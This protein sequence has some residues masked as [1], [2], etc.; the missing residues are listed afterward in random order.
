MM[1]L[2]EVL[3]TTRTLPPPEFDVNEIVSGAQRPASI[4]AEVGCSRGHIWKPTEKQKMAELA[5]VRNY[6][7]VNRV[8]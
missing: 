7:F 5:E 8:V 1:A 2:T 4:A 3:S 6:F